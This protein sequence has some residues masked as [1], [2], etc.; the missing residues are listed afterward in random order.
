MTTSDWTLRQTVSAPTT[1]EV[2]H[3]LQRSPGRGPKRQRLFTEKDLFLMVQHAVLSLAAATMPEGW[4]PGICRITS[5][6]RRIT[7]RRRELAPFRAK[8]NDV[9]RVSDEAE[10]TALYDTVQARRDQRHLTYLRER[11]PRRSVT[12]RVL[13]GAYLDASLAN[14]SGAV[15]WNSPALADTIITKRA[16]W[17]AGVPA[18]QLSV[19]SHGF[20]QSRFAVQNVNPGQIAVEDRYLAGR[21]WFDGDD[22]VRATREVM[23]RLKS[24]APVLFTNSQFSGRSFIAV[25]V[26]ARFCLPLATTPLSIALKPGVPLHM[27]TTIEETPFGCYSTHISPALTPREGAL[28]GDTDTRIADL[29]LQARDILLNFARA[30]PDQI[31]IWDSLI[32]MEK[33]WPQSQ[34]E[35]RKADAP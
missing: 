13:G 7:R 29:A 27:V 3:F 14:G 20:S 28:A 22:A 6:K 15:L 35:Q 10:L 4:W 21:I 33:I 9:L 32:E 19:R 5:F 26:G 8:L 11:S 2:A 18:Y 25:P 16:L 23:R 12:T 17:E 31:R 34:R 30:Y 1:E 24:N